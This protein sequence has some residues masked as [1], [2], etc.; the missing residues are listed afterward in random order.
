MQDTE[1]P[2]YSQTHWLNLQIHSQSIHYEPALQEV[3]RLRNKT[4][5]LYTPE[6]KKFWLSLPPSS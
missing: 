2:V 4:T 3:S 5:I 1:C 6:D